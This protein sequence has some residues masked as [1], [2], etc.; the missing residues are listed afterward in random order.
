MY[1][2]ILCITLLKKEVYMKIHAVN[3]S[4]QNYTRNNYVKLNSNTS[5]Q[6]SIKYLNNTT[7]KGDRGGAIGILAGAA[8]GA[9]GTAF[10]IATGGL[11]GVVA[12]VGYGATV[13][14][15]AA[16]CTHL[17]GIAGSI[18]ED[19]IEGKKD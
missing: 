8:L 2:R 9:L 16:S 12:A 1:N 11:A 3:I 15:G 7:F 5:K 18:I 14:A 6:E 4:Q 19:K 13:T 10:V 17:G